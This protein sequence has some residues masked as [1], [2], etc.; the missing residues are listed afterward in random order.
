MALQI[1][2]LPNVT[3][4]I[5]SQ[6]YPITADAGLAAGSV[7]LQA[8]YDNVGK[9]SVGSADITTGTGVQLSPGETAVIEPPANSKA[10]D[11]FLLF[12]IYVTSA[13]S[14]DVVRPSYIKRR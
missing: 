7:T 3:I 8:D 2:T 10:T 4:A 13:S 6:A 12:L 14:G 11:E 9:I 5:G 1:F